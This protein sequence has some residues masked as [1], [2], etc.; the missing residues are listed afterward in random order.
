[1]CC[2]ENVKYFIYYIHS[3]WYCPWV[4]CLIKL[5]ICRTWL[6][7]AIVLVFLLGLTWLFGFLYLNEDTVVMAYIF[8]GLNSLQGFFIFLFHCVQNEKVICSTSCDRIFTRLFFFFVGSKGISKVHQAS[9]LDTEVFKVL[10]AEPRSWKQQ[11]KFW[12][13]KGKKDE[14]LWRFE[15]KFVGAKFA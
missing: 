5:I 7:G 13:G 1:M 9:F 15:W 8:A 2:L 3:R 11:W 12:F 14:S 4:C 6:R 10:Q